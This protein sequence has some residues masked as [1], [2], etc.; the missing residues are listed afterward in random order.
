[1]GSSS[2]PRIVGGTSETE[3]VGC[4]KYAGTAQAISAW[5]TI[6]MDTVVFDTHGFNTSATRFTIPAGKGGYYQLNYQ[7][8]TTVSE[9][10][11]TVIRKNG[12][13]VGRSQLTGTTN[14]V[15]MY[16]QASPGDYFEFL[17]Y[18]NSSSTT[19]VANK[20]TFAEVIKVGPQ[21][22]GQISSGNYAR[23]DQSNTFGATTTQTIPTLTSPVQIT[24]A[25][26]TSGFPYEVVVDEATTNLCINP[27]FE[28]DTAGWGSYG[29]LANVISR[30]TTTKLIGAASG[31]ATV[32]A[33]TGWYG[34]DNN[35]TGGQ[36]G[37]VVSAGEAITVSFWINSSVSSFL[38]GWRPGGTASPTYYETVETVTVN[39]WHRF[40]KTMIMPTGAGSFTVYIL[41]PSASTLNYS[42]YIDGVQFEKK[43]HATTYCDGSLGSG[44]T[45]SGAAHASSSSRS[46]GFK[47]LGSP[48]VGQGYALGK[49]VLHLDGWYGSLDAIAGP[50]QFYRLQYGATL[51]QVPARMPVS[52]YLYGAWMKTQSAH[53][54]SGYMWLDVYVNGALFRTMSENNSSEWW[55]P[56]GG[57]G[58]TTGRSSVLTDWRPWFIPA[59]STIDLRWRSGNSLAPAANKC[60]LGLVF[61]IEE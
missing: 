11:W 61:I 30:D 44:Y 1:M 21:A 18:P 22:G 53:T 51:A 50:T 3:F 58:D 49:R 52:G 48:I 33:S 13:E 6:N 19:V 54:G 56:A 25:K 45:W 35:S 37:I 4:R 15:T 60:E 29:N 20:E 40:K 46:A 7:I 57:V 16:S 42:F 24:G 27:S 10:F 34:F 26:Q 39:T 8:Q 31:R 43:A 59:G 12:T 14:S 41:N 36:G 28:V 32:G 5:T 17:A 38:F 9:N 55:S 23:V 2:Y 47:Y